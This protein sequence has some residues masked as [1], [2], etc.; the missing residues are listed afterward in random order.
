MKALQAWFTFTQRDNVARV[1]VVISRP[2]C[3][4]SWVFHLFFLE[5]VIQNQ[6]V[7]FPCVIVQAEAIFLLPH[8][9]SS[10]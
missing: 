1:C 5:V 7:L 9:P 2:P 8:F 4:V 6:P 10:N 3:S